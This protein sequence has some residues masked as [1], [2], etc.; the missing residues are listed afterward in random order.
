M[1]K[2]SVYCA[3]GTWQTPLDNSRVCRLYRPLQ[4]LSLTAD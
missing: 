4:A 1:P 3:D 2:R